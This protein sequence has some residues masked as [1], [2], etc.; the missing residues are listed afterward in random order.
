MVRL[1]GLGIWLGI[2]AIVAGAGWGFRHLGQPALAAV[3][4]RVAPVDAKPVI[5]VSGDMSGGQQP[6]ELDAEKAR[7]A[8]RDG[9]MRVVLPDGSSYIVR[10]ERQQ[11]HG[12]GH[13]SVV[14][15]V[16]TATGSQS[17]VLTFGPNAVFGILPTPD[18]HAMQVETHAGGLVTVAPAGGL[19]PRRKLLRPGAPDYR[20]PA[21]PE[22]ESNFD[23]GGTMLAD[24]PFRFK[25]PEGD[26]PVRIDLIAVYS[27]ELVALRG[28]KSIAETEVASLIAIAN[29]AFIDSGT[30]VRLHTAG[31]RE[32]ALPSTLSNA[33][34]LDLL[35]T[36]PVFAAMRDEAAA[37][38]A[39]Y[40]R[41]HPT[42][43]TTCG[44]SWLNGAGLA[45][46]D[47]LDATHGWVVANVKPCGALVLAH[48]LGHAMG[49]AHDRV[50][51]TDAEG[52]VAFGAF[53]FSF[54]IRTRA[55]G[56]IMAD[57]GEAAWLGRFSSPRKAD[58]NGA[59]CGKDDADN[60]RSLD[61][62]AP[63]IAGFR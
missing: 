56:T 60:A 45:G 35:T 3:P 23:I 54:G 10:M 9:Q 44:A 57:P 30:R 25:K 8:L 33:D 38:L 32:A 22:A 11:T 4:T 59:R 39:A 15:R 55:F 29:Q 17:M 52:A 31:L 40:V 48:E 42:D 5:H 20:V 18:G 16:E 61:L 36:D 51:Q 13:W 41:P 47:D 6:I 49:S 1:K 7:R 27:P 21:E 43:D 34:A 58:C 24:R 14:G 63:A 12:G 19:T 37:D 2:G 46:T 62:M 28:G 50:S 53:D 26:A